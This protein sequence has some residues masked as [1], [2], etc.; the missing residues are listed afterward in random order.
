MASPIVKPASTS[1]LRA[2]TTAFA[3]ILHGSG[4]DSI[5][6]NEFT[7][8]CL[9]NAALSTI[10]TL[11]WH[12]IVYKNNWLLG[13]PNTSNTANTASMF[14]NT[15]TYRFVSTIREALQLTLSVTHANTSVKANHNLQLGTYWSFYV[16][17][18]GKISAG[19]VDLSFHP[20]ADNYRSLRDLQQGLKRAGLESSELIIGVDFTKSNIY[21]GLKSFNT[22][23]LHGTFEEIMNPYQFGQ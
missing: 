14:S 8:Q 9:L 23:S 7:K 11:Y 20:I 2:W 22:K 16:V 19:R 3:D 21:N 1:E 13:T 6:G 17:M 5:V 18:G 12:H 15:V 4:T 10:Y